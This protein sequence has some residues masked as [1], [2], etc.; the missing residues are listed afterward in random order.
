M[1]K[2]SL[3][4]L[5]GML[6]ATEKAAIEAF[7]LVGCGDKNKI[8][9]AASQAMR[10][11]LNSVRFSADVAI[12]EYQKDE[13]PGLY[14]GEVVGS[15]QTKPFYSIAVDPV[16]GTTQA[17]KGGFNAISVLALGDYGAFLSTDC[18]YMNKIAVGKKIIEK[19]QISISHPI[20]KNIDLIKKALNK[21]VVKVCVL[22]RPR[23]AELLDRLRKQSCLVKLIDDCDVPA[24]ITTAL[25]DGDI[26]LFVGIGGA[27]EGVI[28]AAAM[29]CLGGY[30]EGC[31]VDHKTF[32]PI[33]NKV[34]SQEELAKGDVMFAAT[35]IT[36]GSL[37]KGVTS[38]GRGY[39]TNSILMESLNKS[40]K[41]VKSYYEV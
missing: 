36:N 6:E 17:A 14:H 34:Y 39:V 32:Q 15:F 8:D 1:P 9:L 23:H 12:A 22:N 25:P 19:T 20:E 30:F 37:L 3:E 21:D 27:P 11:Y 5:F 41:R 33:D 18:F 13:A 38:K 16:E 24:T 35:G 28:S 4:V 26:D 31:L 29:K 40:F 7:K 2:L 10:S